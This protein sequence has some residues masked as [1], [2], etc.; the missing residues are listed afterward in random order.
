[1]HKES[2]ALSEYV[3][4]GDLIAMGMKKAGIRKPACDMTDS[5]IAGLMRWIGMCA[6]DTILPLDGK[7]VLGRLGIGLML[8]VTLLVFPRFYERHGLAQFN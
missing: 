4:P 8:T 1:M 2:S 6:V 3:I 5:D 7:P